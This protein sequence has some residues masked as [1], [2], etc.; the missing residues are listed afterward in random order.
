MLFLDDLLNWEDNDSLV[1]LFV[2]LFFFLI[3]SGLCKMLQTLYHSIVFHNQ[4]ISCCSCLDS[5]IL[6]HRLF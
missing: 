1:R 2:R 4:M 5:L 6:D 3:E